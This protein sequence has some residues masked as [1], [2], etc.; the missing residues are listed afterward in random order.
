MVQDGFYEGFQVVRV[1]LG[2]DEGAIQSHIDLFEE[3]VNQVVGQSHDIC[4]Q[5]VRIVVLLELQFHFKITFFQVDEIF[6][7]VYLE[8]DGIDPDIERVDPHETS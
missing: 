4:C 8:G 3:R 5:Q 1:G 2:A 7:R 6:L